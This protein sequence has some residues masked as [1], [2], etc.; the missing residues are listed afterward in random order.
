MAKDV[1][2]GASIT[3]GT[4]SFTA[5]ATNIDYSI[6]R[7]PVDSTDLSTT[8]GRTAIPA[9]LT[10]GE[11]TLDLHYDPDDF[12]PIDQAP[13]TI[14]ITYP[15]PS[16]GSTAATD[17]FTGFMTNFTITVPE[18]EIISASATIKRSGGNT[19]TDS[20]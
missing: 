1:G 10:D 16:G 5:L 8:G 13:E 14:T 19:H 15:L 17:E 7:E 18:G 3:F 20:A 4:S 6:D 11:I 9:D 12:P 2:N